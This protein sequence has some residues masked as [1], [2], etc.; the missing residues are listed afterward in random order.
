M[1][2][3]N[4]FLTYQW[5]NGNDVK[6]INYSVQVLHEKICKLCLDSFL[7]LVNFYF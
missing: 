3:Q 7:S 2:I 5:L 1:I 4:N 6:Q